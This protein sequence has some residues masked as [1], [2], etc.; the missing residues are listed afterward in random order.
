MVILVA[1]PRRHVENGKNEWYLRVCQEHERNSQVGRWTTN[2]IF[3]RQASY[4][5]C[6][7][8]RDV[9]ETTNY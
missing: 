1:G 3:V 5:K 6:W 8:G 7:C 4:A 2:L 9:D